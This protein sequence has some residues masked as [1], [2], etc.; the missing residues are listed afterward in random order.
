MKTKALT[1]I[2]ALA[3]IMGLAGA[4][5]AAPSDGSVVTVIIPSYRHILV[6]DATIQYTAEELDPGATYT[7]YGTLAVSKYGYADIAWVH[8]YLV[9]QK[10]SVSATAWSPALSSNTDD[11]IEL[12]VVWQG[13]GGTAA[14]EQELINQT[15]TVL[16]PSTAAKDLVT[17]IARGFVVAVSPDLRIRYTT[18]ILVNG[19]VQADTYV[20]T[21][22]YTI[23]DD[24]TTP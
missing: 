16:A 15:G 7:N 18:T 5:S 10:I 3:L 23:T 13:E 14:L 6:G 22:T 9:P 12:K 24:I 2:L 4:A 1:V 20:S 21:V 19:L 11:D 8:N 17:G